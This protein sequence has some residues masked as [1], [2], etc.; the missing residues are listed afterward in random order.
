MKCGGEFELPPNTQK[1]A[2][3]FPVP[4]WDQRRVKQHFGEIRLDLSADFSAT[5]LHK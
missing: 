1:V 5:C 3:L 4:S 2:T